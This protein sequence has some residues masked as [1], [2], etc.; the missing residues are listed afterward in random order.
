MAGALLEHL[1]LLENFFDTAILWGD[2]SGIFCIWTYKFLLRDVALAGNK[3]FRQFSFPN[4]T[5]MLQLEEN[6]ENVEPNSEQVPTP[7]VKRSFRHEGFPYVVN[8]KTAFRGKTSSFVT[9]W[10]CPHYR[11]PT[12]CKATLLEEEH[13]LEPQTVAFTQFKPHS[14]NPPKTVQVDGI[15]DASTSM[16]EKA[17]IVACQEI[18]LTIQEVAKQL[19][20]EFE[21]EYKNQPTIF[22]NIRELE[23]AAR[24]RRTKGFSDW[25]GK[26]KTYPF[27]VCSPTVCL[28][29][30]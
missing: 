4:L 14:C 16:R 22:C 28:F 21:E 5:S 3:F 24:T 13:T 9:Y 20:K 2:T 25:E 23:R 17:E 10:R 7:S 29:V 27:S 11:Q 30:L 15:F 26:V 12:S 18:T 1:L 19:S 6:Q 8:K